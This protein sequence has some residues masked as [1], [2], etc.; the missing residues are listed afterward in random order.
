MICPV[1]NTKG[2][3]ST[4]QLCVRDEKLDFYRGTVLTSSMWLTEFTAIR[5][6]LIAIEEFDRMF[7]EEEK[8]LGNESL[9][10]LS[11]QVRRNE[12]LKQFAD[13]ISRN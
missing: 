4:L 1:G 5:T 8:P 12:L 3:K 2:G 7:M 6:E 11:R 13:L 9:A 10:Y